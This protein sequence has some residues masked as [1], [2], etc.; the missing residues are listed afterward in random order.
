MPSTTSLHPESSSNIFLQSCPNIFGKS[1]DNLQDG[2]LCKIECDNQIL[3][4]WI[5]SLLLFSA[6]FQHFKS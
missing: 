5:W 1:L 6:M 3:D 4:A 2:K